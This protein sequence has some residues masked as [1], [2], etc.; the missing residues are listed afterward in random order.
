MPSFGRSLCSLPL[1]FSALWKI[2]QVVRAKLE[3]SLGK[4]SEWYHFSWYQQ[5]PEYYIII[6]NDVSWGSRANFPRFNDYLNRS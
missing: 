3:K 4:M 5:W 6:L 1:S 2:S